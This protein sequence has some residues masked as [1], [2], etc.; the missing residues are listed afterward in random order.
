MTPEARTST[1][2]ARFYRRI[3]TQGWGD[4]EYFTFSVRSPAL[5]H[6]IAARLPARS[7][8]ILSV[9][10]GGGELEEYLGRLRHRIVG[11]DVSHPMLRRA[12][13]RGL[14]LLVEADARFLPFASAFD[15][16]LF[17]ESI[18]HLDL[19]TALAEARR[20]L[21]QRGRL[22]VTTYA[23]RVAVHRRYRKFA[24]ED[25]VG[26]LALAG[27]RLAERRYLKARR[28]AVVEVAAEEEASVV[29]FSARRAD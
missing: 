7:A 1:A 19:S 4:S 16:V 21:K 6:W 14:E 25:I 2:L 13:R 23:S 29:Y 27:F 11:L 10:C 22:V 28:D 18:G 24:P 5:R 12:A 3:G 8:A 17:P 9:G 20:V 26:A 15:V